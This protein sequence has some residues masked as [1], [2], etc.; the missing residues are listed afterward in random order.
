M[1]K[2]AQKPPPPPLGSCLYAVNRTL[3]AETQM[4]KQAAHSTLAQLDPLLSLQHRSDDCERPK[5]EG[6]F[7]RP[8]KMGL[9]MTMATLRVACS[10][11]GITPK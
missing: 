8:H 6:E 9:E 1:S 5:A 4:A 2:E 10:V 3:W 7:P 11:I